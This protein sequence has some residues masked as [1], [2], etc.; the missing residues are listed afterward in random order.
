MDNIRIEAYT[1]E[2][3]IET[4]EMLKEVL[5]GNLTSEWFKWKHESSPFG[6]SLAWL[7]KDEQGI[8]GCNFFMK[9]ELLCSGEK[10]IAL[11]SCESAVLPRG[12]RKG[13][14]SKLVTQAHALVDSERVW[15]LIGT[16]NSNSIQGFQ[17]LGWT[18][19]LPFSYQ[20]SPIIGL[21]FA[22]II[23]E[24][25]AVCQ[26]IATSL[27]REGVVVNKTP[28]YY[29]WRYGSAS[30]RVYHFAALKNANDPASCIYKVRKL[31]GLNAIV[32]MEA[33]GSL[34]DRKA[35]LRSVCRRN[36]AMIVIHLTNTNFGQMPIKLGAGEYDYITY[37]KGIVEQP[38]NMS[39]GDLEDVL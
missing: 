27:N 11:R 5:P 18:T 6:S 30:G 20:I 36:K 38:W 35:L 8:V 16:P 23:T 28:D 2:D 3:R 4:F 12:R 33:N 34:I 21:G 24:V 14:F 25:D 17:K 29:K 10:Q 32:V 15:A 1:A 39:L 9:Y 31:K 7:A 22:E 19:E 26:V 13:I 37:S